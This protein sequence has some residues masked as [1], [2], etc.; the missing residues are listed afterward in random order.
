MLA[1]H[2]GAVQFIVAE[3]DVT[4]ATVIF[5]ALA[6][7]RD[8]IESVFVASPLDFPSMIIDWSP[9]VKEAGGET[10]NLKGITSPG[11]ARH[12]DPEVYRHGLSDGGI[13]HG[14]A[15]QS[16]EPSWVTIVVD[17]PDGVIHES[18]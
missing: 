7:I 18:S 8:S 5:N 1:D 6:Q 11:M 13:M 10:W 14:E 3:L 4:E 17:Q 9:D 12:W 15:L 2:A 16:M